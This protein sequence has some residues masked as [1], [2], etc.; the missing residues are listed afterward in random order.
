MSRHED[1]RPDMPRLID[2]FVQQG[3][4]VT[5]A[6]RNPWDLTVECRRGELRLVWADGV[7]FGT[8]FAVLA[9][10]R[11]T[12]KWEDTAC[13][14]GLVPLRARYRPGRPERDLWKVGPA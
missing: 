5:W 14:R 2:E 7:I 6:G 9:C 11:A 13:D 1:A 8:R 12:P 4:I 10:S 3:C